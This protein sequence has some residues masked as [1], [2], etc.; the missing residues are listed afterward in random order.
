M[1]RL[2][3]L[4]RPPQNA[5]WRRVVAVLRAVDRPDGFQR[6]PQFRTA[7]TLHDQSRIAFQRP[8]QIVSESGDLRDGPIAHQDNLVHNH[9]MQEATSEVKPGG[10]W[11]FWS[12][13]WVNN[14]YSVSTITIG[15]TSPAASNVPM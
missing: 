12:S 6:R 2:V 11:R 15:S 3:G 13:D 4:R 9:S 14:A 7:V 5:E 10:K 8:I 1:A